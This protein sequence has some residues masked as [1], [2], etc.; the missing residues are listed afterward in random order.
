MATVATEVIQADAIRI[1]F[2]P[3]EQ[4]PQNS[5]RLLL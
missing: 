3:N 4:S 2:G 1:A 5:P